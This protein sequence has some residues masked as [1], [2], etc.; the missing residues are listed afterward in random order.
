ML[1]LKFTGSRDE[2]GGRLIDTALIRRDFYLTVYVLAKSF[3]FLSYISL[4]VGKATEKTA[5]NSSKF[6]KMYRM[7]YQMKEH[8]VRILIIIYS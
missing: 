4:L 1:I 5:V 8:T 7:T 2:S 3:F 6:F